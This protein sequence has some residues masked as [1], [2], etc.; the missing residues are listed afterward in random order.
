MN[1]QNLTYDLHIHSC[2]SPCAANDMT[3]GNIA[4]MAFV[5][6]VKLIA[7]CDHNSAANLPA[8]QKACARHGV[9]L[10]PGI[11]ASTAEEIHMLCYFANLAAAQDMSELLYK[12]LPAIPCR[13]EYF[14]EQIIMN[15]NDEETGRV[16]NLLINATS[17]P[18]GEMVCEVEKRG[19]VCIPAHIDRSSESI[20]SALG[21]MPPTP[22][23]PA[24]ELANPARREEYLRLGHITEKTEILLSSDA[25]YLENIATE[26]RV[27]PS[28]SV[29]WP[30]V[31]QVMASQA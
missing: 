20:L 28:N 12:K 5:A 13:E 19:G 9:L 11:E 25:H 30:L 7:V 17:L 4:G 23:F 26:K 29:L 22:H 16:K 3:P 6:G 15:E 1:A 27:L 31:Q 2:L 18:L 14:G 21:T 24:V 10:L 8:V